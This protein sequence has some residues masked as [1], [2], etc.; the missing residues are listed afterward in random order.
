LLAPASKILTVDA[1]GSV[2]LRSSS[3]EDC[4]YQPQTVHSFLKKVMEKY[5]NKDA[6]SIKRNGVWINWTY[7]EYYQ[8]CRIVAKAFL[9]LG[10]KRFH[11]VG[12]IGFNSPEWFLADIGA[13]FAGGFATGIYTTN[14]PEA[15]QYVAGNCE[16]NIIIVEN[17][18]QLKKILKVWP[19][20]PHVKAVIQYTGVIEEKRENLYSWSELM[21]MGKKEADEPLDAII[22][23]QKPNQCC[24]L[25][26]TSG[27]TGNP[28]GVML[29]H[30]N[31]IWI[32]MGTSRMAKM[33]YGVHKVVSY[34]P[35]SH[36]AAQVMDLYAPIALAGTTYFA[37]PDA[38]KG[39]LVETLREIRPSGFMGVPRV[40]EKIY[41]QMRAAS[42]NIT[43]IKKR[44]A[45][46]AKGVGYRGNIAQM[47][48]EQLPWGWTLAKILLFNKVR[49]TLGL[50][51]CTLLISTGAPLSKEIQEYFLGVNIP[52]YD[53]Y[54][55]SESTGPHTLNLPD[56]FRLGSVG[57]TIWG[58]KSKVMHPDSDGIGEL[59]YFGRH[60]FMGYLNNAEKTGEAIDEDGWLHSGDL[61]YKDR[62]G[63][64]FI[65]GRIKELIITAGGENIPPVLIEDEIKKKTPLISNC[66]LIGDQRKFLSI[67]L[68]LKVNIDPKTQLPTEELN[69]EALGICKQI[70]SNATTVEEAEKDDA[71][72]QHIQKGIDEYNKAAVSRAQKVQ[73]WRILRKDF[74]VAGGELGPTLKLKRPVVMKMYADLADQFYSDTA[75]PRE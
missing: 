74:S 66:M 53:V 34:L 3:R 39:T 32:A 35:L 44:I 54:G 38:L 1:E 19:Q 71:I 24:T 75:T 20:L 10:L 23:S 61:A 2:Q 58:G 41:E 4:E 47:K 52:I 30:D 5:P 29:S 51:R 16:A 55:M 72:A 67:L 70:G 36:I 8:Q 59:C 45:V 31:V 60:V 48:G 17:T 56:D 57:K 26:Y 13:M 11:G 62:D 40:W 12:I 25:I 42:A 68:C 73:K 6:L 49:N 7:S 9:K 65:T 33:E 50:D 64:I 15:C 22:A 28:K 37:Q 27:T 21:E 63:F 69:K 14:S 18:I 43:G 46:W